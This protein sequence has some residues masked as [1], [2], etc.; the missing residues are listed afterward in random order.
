MFAEK[1][2]F[3][4]SNP[5]NLH[6][7]PIGKSFRRRIRP[8]P[9]P[10]PSFSSRTAKAAHIAE[11]VSA[12][13]AKYTDYTAWLA[14]RQ[15]HEPVFTQEL[16]KN[17]LCQMGIDS[18]KAEQLV[19]TCSWYVYQFQKD[20]KIDPEQKEQFISIENKKPKQCKNKSKK[21]IIMKDSVEDSTTTINSLDQNELNKNKKKETDSSCY[22]LEDSFLSN[23]RSNHHFLLPPIH[24]SDSSTSSRFRRVD[25]NDEKIKNSIPEPSSSHR[26]SIFNKTQLKPLLTESSNRLPPI[27]RDLSS[28]Q[29]TLRRHGLINNHTR[30]I[31]RK[32]NSSFSSNTSTEST[33]QK[34]QSQILTPLSKDLDDAPLGT[35]SQRLFGGSEFFAQIMNELEEQ[36]N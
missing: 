23:S 26:Q 2:L 4:N 5:S 31:L 32:Q 29:R 9:P 6:F 22:F 34:F 21:T 20:L 1:P 7:P 28:S 35:R 10:T 25:F 30:S 8:P 18:S 15:N 27:D 36:K 14:T 24:V 17:S 19:S 16:L 33:N 3:S 11:N 13:K 12:L